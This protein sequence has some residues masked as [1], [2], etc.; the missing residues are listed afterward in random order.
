MSVPRSSSRNKAFSAWGHD[1]VPAAMI[2]RLIHHAEIL[3]LK[4]TATGSARK[5]PRR[6]PPLRPV[7]GVR[8]CTFN[9]WRGGEIS[10]VDDKPH[11]MGCAPGVAVDLP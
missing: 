1:V 2:H 6:E 5:G 3:S 7:R 8:G 9:R 10:T 11:G 4:A